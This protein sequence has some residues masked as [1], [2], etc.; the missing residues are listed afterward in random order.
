LPTN[1]GEHS[2]TP[3]GNPQWVPCNGQPLYILDPKQQTRTAI[4]G[5][6]SRGDRRDYRRRNGWQG[7]RRGL[8]PLGWIVM[9][10]FDPSATW[11]VTTADDN[12]ESTLTNPPTVAKPPPGVK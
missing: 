12:T 1:A 5:T 8:G 6:P 3:G 9:M 11:S 2:L 4:P 10:P 7:R